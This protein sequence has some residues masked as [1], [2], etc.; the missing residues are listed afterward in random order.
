VRA[1]RRLARNAQSGSRVARYLERRPF[2]FASFRFVQRIEFRRAKPHNSRTAARRAEGDAPTETYPPPPVTG[3]A[4]NVIQGIKMSVQFRRARFSNGRYGKASAGLTAADRP[5]S[6][7]AYKHGDRFRVS[8][9]IRAR[10]NY[11]AGFQY[12]NV[13]GIR[14]G[15]KIG[16]RQQ[17]EREREKRHTYTR[18]HRARHGTHR[19][20][21]RYMDTY[22]V[23]TQAGFL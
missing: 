19:C 18:V 14:C 7:D 15:C 23:K 12:L 20:R 22:H 2:R 10:W 11:P 17:R 3:S 13:I 16:Q 6:N 1:D 5:V 21:H 4:V 9:E 8:T